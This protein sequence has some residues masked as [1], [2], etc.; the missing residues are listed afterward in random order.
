MSNNP[1]THLYSREAYNHLTNQPINY[2]C[3]RGGNQK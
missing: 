1:L 2:I 3:N